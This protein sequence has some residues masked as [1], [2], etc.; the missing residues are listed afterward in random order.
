MQ[1]NKTQIDPAYGY[2]NLVIPDYQKS[3]DN[4]CEHCQKLMS[5]IPSK[6]KNGDIHHSGH[7]MCPFRVID[8]EYCED[9][10]SYNDLKAEYEYKCKLLDYALDLACCRFLFISPQRGKT[11]KEILLDIAR[12]E[13][14]NEKL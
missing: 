7:I 5:Q 11:R 13:L 12:K 9:Y 4:M 14:E 2:S 10:M 3:L 6:A 1:D 8:N